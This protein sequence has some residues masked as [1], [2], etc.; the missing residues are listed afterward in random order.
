MSVY[1]LKGDAM[2]EELLRFAERI[3][4]LT[5]GH[6]FVNDMWNGK[7]VCGE[8]IT[9]NDKLTFNDNTTQNTAFRVYNESGTR[10]A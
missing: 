10:I 6:L 8:T 9:S 7:V 5:N 2:S 3:V 1:W 4:S